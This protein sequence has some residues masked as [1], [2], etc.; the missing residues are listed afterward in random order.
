MI[1]TEDVY[2]LMA[3]HFL[4]GVSGRRQILTRIKVI[5]MLSKMLAD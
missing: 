5:R 2:N 4:N 1:A 3:N